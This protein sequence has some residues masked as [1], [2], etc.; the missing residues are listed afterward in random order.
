MTSSPDIPTRNAVQSVYGGGDY[1]G[2]IAAFSSDGSTL[3]YGSYIGGSQ[4]DVLEGLVVRS[5]HAYATGLSSSANLHQKHSRVQ[6]WYG[7]GQFDAI[8]FGVNVPDDR[9]CR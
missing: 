8:L 2:F 7:G 6:P 9:S 5:G 1:D 4:H 3:C